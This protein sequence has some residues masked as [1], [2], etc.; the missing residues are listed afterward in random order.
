MTDVKLSDGLREMTDDELEKEFNKFFWSELY[1]DC[2][3]LSCEACD[4]CEC[5]TYQ[6][7]F[8]EYRQELGYA[9]NN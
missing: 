3:V 4:C 5:S 7:A 1:Q 9:P 6:E 2:Y 8:E